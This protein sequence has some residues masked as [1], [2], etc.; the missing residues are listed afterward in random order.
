MALNRSLIYSTS[1]KIAHAP[2]VVH[3]WCAIVLVFDALESNIF[4]GGVEIVRE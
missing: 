4:L 1:F 3:K 2:N